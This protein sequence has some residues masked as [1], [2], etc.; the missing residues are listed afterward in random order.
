VLL[1]SAGASDRVRMM[2]PENIIGRRVVP[3]VES[4]VSFADDLY[5]SILKDFFRGDDFIAQE[6]DGFP[7]VFRYPPLEQFLDF[8]SLECIGLDPDGNPI[9]HV[10]V[11]LQNAESIICN[12]RGACERT[13]CGF[14]CTVETTMVPVCSQESI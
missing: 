5:H 6:V 13:V 11:V 2:P 12:T 9:L 1:D 7:Q 4:R 14:V 3:H 10:Y 8:V